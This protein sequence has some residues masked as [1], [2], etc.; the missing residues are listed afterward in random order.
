MAVPGIIQGSEV[1]TPVGGTQMDSTAFRNAALAPGKIGAAIGQEV[2]PLFDEVSQKIQANRNARTVFDADLAMRTA[3]EDFT[4]NLHKMPDEGTWLP[5]WQETSQNVRDQVLSGPNVGPDVKRHL[6]MMLDNWQAGTSAEVRTAALVKGIDQTRKSALASSNMAYA[7]GDIAGG[8]NILKAATENY[9]FHP[10]EA[11]TLMAQGKITA[12]TSAA[13]SAIASDPIN[14]GKI[15]DKLKDDVPPR[16]FLGIQA[17]AREAKNA[18]QSENYNSYSEQVDASPDHTIDPSILRDAVASEDIKQSHMDKIVARMKTISSAD[19]KAA[20]DKE[21]QDFNTSMMEAQEHDWVGD[22]TPEKT[23][24]D[25]KAEGLSWAN[26]GLRRRLNKFIDDK[27]KAAK[28]QGE[29]LER[30]VETQ[31][32][33]DMK[34]DRSKYGFTVPVTEA[35]VKGGLTLTPFSPF[36]PKNP[37]SRGPSTTKTVFLPGGLDALSKP[38]N[39]AQIKSM[40]GVS[41]EELIRAEQQHYANIQQKMREWFQDPSNKNAKYDDAKTHLIELEKPFI[42][43]SVAATLSPKVANGDYKQPQDV[44]QALHDGKITRD[45]ALKILQS[46]FGMK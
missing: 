10:S 25:M 12:T 35:E 13:D 11:K 22:T 19:K 29:A 1:N 26:M 41:R 30:P 23:M 3:K 15:I 34:Q 43:G 36:N 2:S 21:T 20:N 45:Q 6:T 42:M 9:A 5:Q 24:S 7:Q 18:K 44:K 31:I 39:D 14:A 16:I 33:D 8:D 32:F 37:I 38:E 28:K 17:H 27:S 46:Q 40:Y 4:A